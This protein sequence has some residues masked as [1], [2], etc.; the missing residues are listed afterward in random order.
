MSDA[1]WRWSPVRACQELPG[2]GLGD[3]P[4]VLDDLLAAH[5]DAV[6]GDGDRPRL[7]VVADPDLQRALGLG[8]ARTRASSSSRSRSMASEA[9]EISS[10]RKISLLLYSECTIRSRIWTTSA[11][12]LKLSCSVCALTGLP[13]PRG[14]LNQ[15]GGRAR[16]ETAASRRTVLLAGSL[17]PGRT[18]TD[19]PAGFPLGSGLLGSSDRGRQYAERYLVPGERAP[20]GRSASRPAGPVTATSCGGRTSTWSPGSAWT[21]TGSPSSGPGSSQAEGEFSTE[22]LAHYR[23]II[24]RCVA[25]GIAPVVTYNHFTAPHWFAQARR[26]ARRGGSGAV[27]PLLRRRGRASG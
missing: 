8:A 6:V 20:D 2:P 13:S 16:R 19:V 27:R 18:V 5:A 14:T 4:D 12:K 26:V 3:G 1:S 17:E 15:T 21:P 9:F 10:R 22:A 7:V 23:A 25:A 11:W 24:D